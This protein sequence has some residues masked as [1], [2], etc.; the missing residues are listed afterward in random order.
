[1]WTIQQ[2]TESSAEHHDAESS[3]L[4]LLVEAHLL[5]LSP[6][7][8]PAP[9]C[10]GTSRCSSSSPNTGD[11]QARDS[12]STRVLRAP[13]SETHGDYASS[14]PGTSLRSKLEE[15]EAWSHFHLQRVSSHTLSGQRLCAVSG[16]TAE[17][18]FVR[19]SKVQRE[20]LCVCGAA[21]DFS[22]TSAGR[23]PQKKR[24]KHV[25]FKPQKIQTRWSLLL[26]LSFT[27]RRETHVS[28][29]TLWTTGLREASSRSSPAAVT[30][31]SSGRSC[32]L[33]RLGVLQPCGWWGPDL[34]AV[35]QTTEHVHTCTCTPRCTGCCFSPLWPWRQQSGL[36]AERKQQIKRRKRSN[37]H[38]DGAEPPVLLSNCGRLTERPLVVNSAGANQK[39]LLYLIYN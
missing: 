16:L 30:R 23:T 17:W 26:Q 14:S 31:G 32:G 36:Q 4:C 34:Q 29:R 18:Q 24:M 11:R 38:L 35:H 1:M 2:A 7:P 21:G 22:T 5:D 33:C 39:C 27:R 20:G 25:L 13:G 19:P 8:V 3:V 15:T 9:T 12:S 37:S 10:R 6:D 28:S